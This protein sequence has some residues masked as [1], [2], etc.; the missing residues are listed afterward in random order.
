MP[1]RRPL[2]RERPRPGTP[3]GTLHGGNRP[4]N[5]TGST[6]PLAKDV[7]RVDA[8]PDA[9]PR[10]VQ[11]DHRH[12]AGTARRHRRQAGRRDETGPE[13]RSEWNHL[14][15][16]NS[17]DG[18]RSAVTAPTPPDRG[19]TRGTPAGR[20]ESAGTDHKCRHRAGTGTRTPLGATDE[21]WHRQD[22]RQQ[23]PKRRGTGGKPN[24]PDPQRYMP[25]TTDVSSLRTAI[26]RSI[27]W[28]AVRL[29]SENCAACSAT[30]T[31]AAA[32]YAP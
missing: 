8:R 19:H 31:S 20:R 32:T 16:Q 9:H 14:Q 13:A 21:P 11:E 25:A 1:W 6:R 28:R 2:Q 15:E 17:P 29:K 23:A 30:L 18:E 10:A 12:R 26:I 5:P 27:I 24:D 4:G 3:P 22:G 7:G